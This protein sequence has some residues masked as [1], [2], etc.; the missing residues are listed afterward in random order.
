MVKSDTSD[1]IRVVAELTASSGSYARQFI[2]WLG[3]GSAGGAVA[4]LTL[5]ANLPAPDHALRALLPSLAAFVLGVICA[6]ASLLFASLRDGAGAHHH[7]QAHNRDQLND[8]LAAT[9]QFFSSSAR[10]EEQ[11][12]AARNR[13]VEQNRRFHEQGEAAWSRRQGWRA[14][15]GLSV[16][17]AACAFVAGVSWPIV[18]IASG[19]RL[20]P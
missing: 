12:N 10:Q 17:I 11:L 9:P 19:G 13:M 18:L 4:L 15:F 6:A 5:A 2:L 20:A 3:I 1:T 16:T 8:A 14:A 7:G